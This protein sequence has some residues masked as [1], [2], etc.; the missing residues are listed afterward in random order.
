M[1]SN[2]DPLAGQE[3]PTAGWQHALRSHPQHWQGNRYV[4]PVLS[5]RAKG[6]SI[7][8]NLN[9]DQVCNFQCVYCQ[10]DRT[11]GS[12]S[13]EVDL[14]VL[15]DELDHML[16]AV[17]SG[18]LFRQAPFAAAPA[19]MQRL[20]D[21]AF[22]GDGEPTASKVFGR[23]ARIVIDTAAA[24]PLSA[25]R[26]IVVLTNAT[27]LDRPAV[28]E[29][30]DLLHDHAGQ[31]WAKLDAG[32]EHHYRR[33]NRCPIP[34][35]RIL[36]NIR[37]AA[38]RWRVLIQSMWVNLDGQPPDSAEIEAF[39]DRLREILAAGGQ[40]QEVQACTLARPPAE[41]FVSALSQEQLRA[42][43]DVVARRTKLP[44]EVF[45]SPAE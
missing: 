30:F 14:D 45:G 39:A 32:T 40:L 3:S 36:D 19:A 5:R 9:P 25:D 35:S 41:A 24:R 17:V 1:P 21:I 44:V 42:I 15:R 33:M 26:K 20:S 4:Y 16:D 28:Q 10:V 43:A 11:G 13:G 34:L 18:D 38:Q 27:L 22:S 2:H 7:G 31:I 29:A 8:I 23:A 37:M 12:R 6:V